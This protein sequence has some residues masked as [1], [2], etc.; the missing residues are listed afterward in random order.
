[1]ETTVGN[2]CRNVGTHVIAQSL[3]GLPRIVRP[4]CVLE[5]RKDLGLHFARQH[6]PTRH[7]E[8]SCHVHNEVVILAEGLSHGLFNSLTDTFAVFRRVEICHVIKQTHFNIA[9]QILKRTLLNHRGKNAIEDR[10]ESTHKL[11]FARFNRIVGRSFDRSCQIP[12]FEFGVNHS[13]CI[14]N[15]L[16][17]FLTHRNVGLAR[18]FESVP[19]PLHDGI[20]FGFDL[21][22]RIG[23]VIFVF[24]ENVH[25]VLEAVPVEVSQRQAQLC[26][27]LTRNLTLLHRSLNPAYP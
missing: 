24:L 23:D 4:P 19:L 27:K 17:Y 2:T 25:S 8:H 1:M 14:R 11:L 18:H 13:D 15:A 6:I 26:A 12:T 5:S 3:E 7:V 9:Y 21:G 22:H 16:R 10:V 20:G